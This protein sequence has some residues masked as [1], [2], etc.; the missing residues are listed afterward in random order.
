MSWPEED[1]DNNTQDIIEEIIQIQNLKWNGWFSALGRKIRV[2]TL[3]AKLDKMG[4]AGDRPPRTWNQYTVGKN[5][6]Y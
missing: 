4:Y 5:L 1:K 2:D 3:H 6:E